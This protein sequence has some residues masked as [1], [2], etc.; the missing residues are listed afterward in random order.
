MVCLLKP[1]TIPFTT[2]QNS[3]LQ[4]LFHTSSSVFTCRTCKCFINCSFANPKYRVTPGC[5]PRFL[6]SVG[7]RGSAGSSRGEYAHEGSRASSYQGSCSRDSFPSRTEC[8]QCHLWEALETFS[9][10][11]GHKSLGIKEIQVYLKRSHRKQSTAEGEMSQV[12]DLLPC[13]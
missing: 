12:S 13:E 2:Q 5:D 9:S 4:R 8:V 6:L 11:S 7:F 10:T 1:N 3:L